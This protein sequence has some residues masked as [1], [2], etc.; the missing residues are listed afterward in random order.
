MA[1]S[2]KQI[3]V[4]PEEIMAEVYRLLENRKS[5]TMTAGEFRDLAVQAMRDMGLPATDADVELQWDPE[6]PQPLRLYIKTQNRNL[7]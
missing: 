1:Q 2:R 5:K 3:D 7:H 6:A 4:G